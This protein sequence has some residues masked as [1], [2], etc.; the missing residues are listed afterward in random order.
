MHCQNSMFL[1]NKQLGIFWKPFAASTAS[2]VDRGFWMNLPLHLEHLDISWSSLIFN[3]KVSMTCINWQNIKASNLSHQHILIALH[4]NLN[5][6]FSLQH[7]H[8][9]HFSFTVIFSQLQFILFTWLPSKTRFHVQ[10]SY[11]LSS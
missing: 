10:T 9:L 6:P 1:L 2:S 8:L 7:R 11:Y 5:L 4:C 3:W